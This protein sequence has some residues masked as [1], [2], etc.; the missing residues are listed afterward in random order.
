MVDRCMRTDS[1]RCDPNCITLDVRSLVIRLGSQLEES[2][3]THLSIIRFSLMPSQESWVSS[4]E[5]SSGKA[6]LLESLQS[7]G[8]V[9][10]TCPHT[11]A[12]VIDGPAMIHCDLARCS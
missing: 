7:L 1:S 6:D 12:H 5:K 10:D 8:L 9:P 4:R 2:F 3:L 11:T